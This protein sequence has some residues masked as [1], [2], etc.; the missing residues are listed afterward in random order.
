MSRLRKCV[1]DEATIISLDNVQV[2]ESLNYVEKPIA[3]LDRK[4]KALL[5][6]AGQCVKVQRQHRRG[7][8]WTCESEDETRKPYPAIF[9]SA[10]FEDDV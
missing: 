7:S 8:K 4:T 2:D 6:K 5:N 9:A 10:D 3:I 1:A